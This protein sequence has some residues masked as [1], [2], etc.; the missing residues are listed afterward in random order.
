MATATKETRIYWD[1][2]L[3]KPMRLTI[4]GTYYGAISRTEL[5]EELFAI[6]KRAVNSFKFPRVSLDYKVF[7]ASRDI[8]NPNRLIEASD[9]GKGD[10]TEVTKG[11]NADWGWND[12]Y[13][14]LTSCCNESGQEGLP[15]EPAIPHAY[16]IN[17]VTDKE[18]EVILAWRKVYWIE[19]LLSNADDFD[20]TYTDSNIKTYSRA[21]LVQQNT[22]RYKEFKDRAKEV[23]TN[24]GRTET[25]KPTL[26]SINSDDEDE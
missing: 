14:N 21:N 2:V 11:W 15:S 26:G 20:N 4:R 8:N 5:D 10:M 13:P 25:Y 19:Y 23:E 7:Y 16:F 12:E 22:T 9:K 17:P 3:Y 24:Y 18:I 1:D 6:A